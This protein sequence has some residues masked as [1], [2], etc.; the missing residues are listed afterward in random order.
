MGSKGVEGAF[1]ARYVPI[2]RSLACFRHGRAGDLFFTPNPS[3]ASAEPI[4]HRLESFV[5]VEWERLP[6]RRGPETLV[7]KKDGRQVYLHSAYDPQREARQ[8]AGQVDEP[9]PSNIVVV[10]GLGLGYH[11]RALLERLPASQ[12]VIVVE[13]QREIAESFPLDRLQADFPDHRSVVV[14]SDW[15]QFKEV[16]TSLG[17]GM[18]NVVLLK[19]PAAAQVFAREFREFLEKLRSEVKMLRTNLATVINFAPEWQRNF[20]ENLRFC[21]QVGTVS[22][23]FG[24]WKNR[25]AILAAAGPSLNKQIRLLRRAKGRALIISVGSATRLL[26]KEGIEPDLVASIDAGRPNYEGIF[27]GMDLPRTPLVFDPINH[28]KIL[29]HYRGPKVMMS[30]HRS[31][32]WLDRYFRQEVG[33]IKIGGSIACTVFDLLRQAGADPI[34]M[35]GQDLAFTDEQLHAD[36]SL[37]TI[38]VVGSKAEELEEQGGKKGYKKTDQILVWVKGNDGKPIISNVQMETYI[39]WFEEELRVHK[40]ELRVINATEGGARIQGAEVMTFSQALD[41]FIGQD[42]SEELRQLRRGLLADPGFDR[43]G[44]QRQVR[45]TRRQVERGLPHARRAL[46]LSEELLQHFSRGTPCPVGKIVSKLESLDKKLKAARKDA[47]LISYA[48]SPLTLL[49]RFAPKDGSEVETCRQ[50]MRVY[51]SIAQAFE[52]TLPLL[53][54]LEESL[55]HAA[56]QEA[57]GA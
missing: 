49:R 15:S 51:R 33:Q 11:L 3:S 10:F 43:R 42:L 24:A 41:Q 20:L 50:S 32:R 55:S 13:P 29:Q 14:V 53:R 28:Y 27:K 56:Q 5:R 25:P 44:L 48:L 37:E 16:Y 47:F 26:A 19:L 39:H 38:D 54:R 45:R 40:G 2:F 8:W 34:I 30:V 52:T 35:I 4:P 23:I 31:N 6:S 1:L 18:D 12:R 46:K 17:G 7:L 36:G 22:P 21:P 57:L 9:S